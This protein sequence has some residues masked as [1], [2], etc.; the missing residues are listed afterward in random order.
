MDEIRCP[1]CDHL[2]PITRTTCERCGARL[3]GWEADEA[4]PGEE[5][6]ASIEA[7]GVL[8]DSEL[9]AWL[10]EVLGDETPEEEGAPAEPPPW[11]G[12]P[13]AE[14]QPH[15]PAPV[16][17]EGPPEPVRE[18]AQPP[19]ARPE[20]TPHPETPETPPEPEEAPAP[21]R[22]A[23]PEAP[24]TAPESPEPEPIPTL[25]TD[26]PEIDLGEPVLG[27]IAL[28]ESEL[29]AL[30]DEAAELEAPPAE[31][32][33]E[34]TELVAVEEEPEPGQLPDWLAAA[35]Q[36]L[37]PVDT[38]LASPL[39]GIPD[40]LPLEPRLAELARKEEVRPVFGVQLRGEERRWAR[41]LAQWI[42]LEDQG[43][44]AEEEDIPA[45]P[46]RWWRLVVGMT[47]LTLLG[48][49][50]LLGPRR[51]VGSPAPTRGAQA[52]VNLVEGLP[53][54]PVLVVFLDLEPAWAPEVQWSAL[55]ALRLLEA[56]SPTYV[57]FSTQ[58][59]GSALAATLQDQV[60]IPRERFLW[61]GYLPGDLVAMALLARWPRAM[62]LSTTIPEAWRN[63]SDSPMVL[64]VSDQATSTREWIEQLS[65]Y[66]DRST[67]LVVIGPGQLLPVLEP[68]FDHQVQAWVA[69]ARDAAA[70]AAQT[71][72]A[73]PEST[74]RAWAWSWVLALFLGLISALTLALWHRLQQREV[75]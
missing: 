10:R 6:V 43:E 25:E 52:F 55:A 29:S 8:D 70:L 19:E 75:T 51:P 62:A 63:L 61:A 13:E 46:W 15:E 42:Q 60:P 49:L 36:A 57:V 45:L 17:E 23:L 39:A 66:L 67:A 31:P 40:I 9:Q 69:G 27:E 7:S 2:N 33:G 20:P 68:Y 34:A 22:E 71:G 53:D 54:N 1:E 26:F 21:E 30:L 12:E 50:V 14:P 3:S 73:M 41:R 72:L 65:P 38:D 18:E 28:D 11:A 24:V 35:Q 44:E 58:P 56:R 32:E 74:W 16:L 48:L 64:L 47:L 4:F 59:Y 37:E 5:P